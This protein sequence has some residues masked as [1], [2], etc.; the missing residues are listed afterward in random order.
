MTD[1]STIQPVYYFVL[2][3]G[4]GTG[5]YSRADLA[6]LA[7]QKKLL[8]ES[9]IWNEGMDQWVMIRDI[10]DL[11]D[12]VA[13]DQPLVITAGFGRRFM[14][15]A[16]DLMLIVVLFELMMAAFPQFRNG[17]ETASLDPQQLA[18]VNLWL[19]AFIYLYYLLSMGSLGKGGTLGYH[20]MKLRL[21]SQRQ[22]AKLSV[23]QILLW[24]IGTVI[25]PIGWL[26]YFFDRRKRMLHNIVSH[27]IV[28]SCKHQ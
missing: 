25:L 20:A 13:Q 1:T 19:S 27:T 22:S 28:I 17:I 6:N 3:D 7:Q 2:V 10:P 14:A 4:E 18:G 21:V 5:P 23:L 16:I 8:A 11:Q 9:C 12:L 24:C 26:W 15:G